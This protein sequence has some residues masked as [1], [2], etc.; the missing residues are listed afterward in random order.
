MTTPGIVYVATNPA[1]P[2]LVKIGQTTGSAEERMASLYTSGVPVPFECVYA[3]RVSDVEKV[4]VA[5]HQAFGPYRI[6]PRREFFEIH[7]DQAIALLRLLAI[8]DATPQTSREADREIDATSLEARDNLRRRRPSLNFRI[9]SLPVGS[10]LRSIHNAETAVVSGDRSVTF[11]GEDTSL[12]NATRVLLELDYPV[13]PTSHWTFEGRLLS[14]I[15]EETYS[16][17]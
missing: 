8:E 12:S 2:N 16:R 17:E 9:M 1:M 6:N 5:F 4:E 3:A 15:Y 13:A 7:P 10:I 11:R 14:E